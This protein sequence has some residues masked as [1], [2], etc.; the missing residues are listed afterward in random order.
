MNAISLR[1]GKELE[2]PKPK[3]P[4]P[5]D[6]GEVEESE[7]PYIPPPPF[8]PPLPFPQRKAMAQTEKQFGKFLDV[9]KK[10]YINIPFTD[11]LQQM[12]LYVKFLKEILSKKRKFEG[13]QQVS[14]NQDCSALVQNKLPPK[15]GD[16]GSFCVPIEIGKCTYNALCD[17]GASVS[18]I[19]LSICKKLDLGEPKLVDMTLF[20]ADRSTVSP[21][22]ILENIPI[23]VGKFFVP[24][25]FIVLDIQADFSVPIILG[26]PFLATAGTLIDV[27][28]GVL[29]FSVGGRKLNLVSLMLSSNLGLR[30]SC[31]G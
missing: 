25:D 15:L 27:K 3:V 11:A 21:T 20:M 22:G 29:S 2:D 6:G 28:E 24:V 26:R 30:M 10:L 7:A 13:C 16:P 17:L 19:P 23:Q 12:P 9:L 18:L 5:K 4:Q 8:K 1:S 31:A 14:L